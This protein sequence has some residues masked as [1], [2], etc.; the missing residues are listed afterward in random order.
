MLREL[1]AAGYDG[2]LA[3]ECLGPQAKAEPVRTA[4]RD[5]RILRRY[6][7]QTGEKK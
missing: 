6:L 3:V 7:E 4:Q 1:C 2:P 5:L